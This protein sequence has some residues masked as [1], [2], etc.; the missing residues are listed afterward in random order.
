MPA[1]GSVT[2]NSDARMKEMPRNLDAS[3]GLAVAVC[4]FYQDGMIP[5]KPGKTKWED[6]IRKNPDRLKKS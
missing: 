4:H 2:R 3:D 1:A 6:F 5:V